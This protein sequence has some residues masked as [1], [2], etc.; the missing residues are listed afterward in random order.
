MS[1]YI[2]FTQE[3]KDRAAATDLELFLQSRGETPLPSGRD[4]RLASDHS[5]TIRG[6]YWYDHSARQG[7]NAISFVQRFCHLGYADAVSL[8]LCGGHVSIK[9]EKEPPKEFTP[10]AANGT[11]RHVFAYLVQHRRIHREVVSFFCPHAS[12]LR[13]CGTSQLRV[14]GA[15]CSGRHA[16]CPPA[17]YRQSGQALPPDGG[18]QQRAIQ[19]SLRRRQLVTLCIRVPYRPAVLYHPASGLLAGAELCGLLRHSLHAGG[20]DAPH[21]SSNRPGVP[22][23]RQR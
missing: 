23:S 10:P 13:G 12:P 8:L 1:P 5:V 16:S 21:L 6:N 14:C 11:M 9:P 17:R 22:L 3:Q 18:G 4:K 7:G 20:A 2:H 19:L 15:G